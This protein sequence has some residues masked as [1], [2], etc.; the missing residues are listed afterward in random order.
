MRARLVEKLELIEHK[1]ANRLHKA[2]MY[3]GVAFMLFFLDTADG[4][5]LYG[6]GVLTLA[7]I[8]LSDKKKTH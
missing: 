2:H 7:A 8:E 4:H 1:V 6:C 3:G 5:I